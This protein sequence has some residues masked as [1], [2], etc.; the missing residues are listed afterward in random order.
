M[1]RR[2][3]FFMKGLN[4]WSH[5]KSSFIRIQSFQQCENCS[6]SFFNNNKKRTK[7]CFW[8]QKWLSFFFLKLNQR[9][10]N[11]FK[12]KKKKNNI[13]SSSAYSGDEVHELCIVSWMVYTLELYSITLLIAFSIVAYVD[14]NFIAYST[15]AWL[16]IAHFL[17][18]VQLFSLWFL[19]S[20]SALHFVNSIR[21][22]GKHCTTCTCN[23]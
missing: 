9:F 13:D 20:I 11:Y 19:C 22:P 7:N 10:T 12:K 6:F 1:V 21:F 15:F 3:L 4:S 14:I 8:N 23:E 2:S 16:T 5:S 18:P 17:V